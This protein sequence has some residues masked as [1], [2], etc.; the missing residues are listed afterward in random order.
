MEGE[1]SDSED[2]NAFCK[3]PVWQR[4]IITVAGATVNILSGVLVMI[5]VVAT[6]N[7]FG[8]TVIAEFVPQD[9]FVEGVEY[10]SS[11]EAG[12]MVGDEIIAVDGTRVHILNDLHYEIV[13]EGYE[14]VSV[15]VL[16]DGKKVTVDNIQFPRVTEQ[17]VTFGYRD[18]LVKAQEKSFGVVV[19]H[20]IFRTTTTV[21]MIWESLIDMVSG[22][23]GIEAVSG[24]V[25]VTK[26]LAEAASYGLSDFITIT[27]IL[28][29]NLGMMNLL[30][31]PALDGG[32]LFFQ[33][34]ELVFRHPVP[35]KIEGAVHF[36][37]IV[38]LFLLMILI[39]MKD[40]ISLF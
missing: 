13:H 36:A 8:S 12:L 35:R 27:V 29:I 21:K 6:S 16:R 3:K 4:M 38:I 23:Y 10:H 1:D 14:A 9:S 22:K 26:T 2:D 31:L 25:G 20:G 32:R 28:S 11:E 33:F 24:P 39:T 17:G 40:V 15:T 5:I 34:I 19:K 18:F 37:G 30:P 7:S